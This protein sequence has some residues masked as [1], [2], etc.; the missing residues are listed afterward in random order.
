MHKAKRQATRFFFRANNFLILK[1]FKKVFFQKYF[2]FFL[3]QLFR[4]CKC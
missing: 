3:G 4:M 2:L 1:D